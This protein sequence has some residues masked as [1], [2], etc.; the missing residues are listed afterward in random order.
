MFRRLRKVWPAYSMQFFWQRHNWWL[1]PRYFKIYRYTCTKP[2]LIRL[3][4][5]RLVGLLD[6]NNMMGPNNRRC[7]TSKSSLLCSVVFRSA[8]FAIVWRRSV[9]DL[10]KEEMCSQHD[11]ASFSYLFVIWV[12]W[13]S[14]IYKFLTIAIVARRV[15]L[16]VQNCLQMQTWKGL[17][18]EV[19]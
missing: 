18:V 5:S 9:E 17:T 11:S 13:K 15:V 16:D 12:Q 1:Q 8:I 6:G 14:R 7:S 4:R 10:P 3:H 2:L 19:C